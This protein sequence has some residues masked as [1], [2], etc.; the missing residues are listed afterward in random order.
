MS[1][2]PHEKSGYWKAAYLRICRGHTDNTLCEYL[3][4]N[5]IQSQAAELATESLPGAVLMGL[6]AAL[7][8]QEVALVL[9]HIKSTADQEVQRLEGELQGNREN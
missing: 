4:I 6:I 1:H 5:A 2:G 7:S 3:R 8:E 9:L